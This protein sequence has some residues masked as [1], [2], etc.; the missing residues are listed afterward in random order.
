MTPKNDEQIE[1]Y[2]VDM[3]GGKSSCQVTKDI[4]ATLTCTHYGEPAV[5]YLKKAKEVSNGS[6]SD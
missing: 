4:S 6:D 5:C 2:C 3:G 1:V